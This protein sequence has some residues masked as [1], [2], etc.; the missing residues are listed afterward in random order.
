MLGN[1]PPYWYIYD[2]APTQFTE[3]D[4]IQPD[5]FNNENYQPLNAI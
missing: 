5:A 4:L 2:A 3:H 1:P